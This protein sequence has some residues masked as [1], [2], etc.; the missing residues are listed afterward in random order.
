MGISVKITGYSQG[1]KQGT[2]QGNRV[3]G[4]GYTPLYREGCTLY[5][6]M[7]YPD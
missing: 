7:V 2:K 5:P 4:T 3:E 1:T 6:E